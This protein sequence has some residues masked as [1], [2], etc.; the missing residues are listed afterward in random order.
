MC[1]KAVEGSTQSE[2]FAAPSGHDTWTQEVFGMT[3]CRYADGLHPF[4]LPMFT[5]GFGMLV[6]EG[7]LTL[8]ACKVDAVPG[9]MLKTKLSNLEALSVEDFT[10]MLSA[11]GSQHITVKAAADDL[12]IVPSGYVLCMLS[13][14]LVALRWPR[15]PKCKGE[16]QRVVCDMTLAQQAFPAQC[17][18]EHF[19]NLFQF[20]SAF[21]AE[22][23]IENSMPS[24]ET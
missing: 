17:S 9:D 6:L 16:Y 20:F 19:S 15:L 22:I 11:E 8:V 1:V 5:L 2:M 21:R 24:G 4:S 3:L 14:S 10:G 12:L 23:H 13:S 18:T 7:K